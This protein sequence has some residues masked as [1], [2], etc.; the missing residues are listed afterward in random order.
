MLGYPG[1]EARTMLCVL[2]TPHHDR[3]KSSLKSWSRA[4]RAEKLQNDR[5]A[6]KSKRLVK[7]TGNPLEA[8][9][10][11]ACGDRWAL[12]E[13]LKIDRTA[14]A[15]KDHKFLARSPRS[16]LEESR[17]ESTKNDPKMAKFSLRP[18]IRYLD[19]LRGEAPEPRK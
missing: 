9:V 8:H 14:V 17:E 6:E 1:Q 18:L 16:L 3:R 2:P 19:T 11:S 15:A 5:A 10:E 12:I 4:H 13:A 7:T